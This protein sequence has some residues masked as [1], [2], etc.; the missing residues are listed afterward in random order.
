MIPVDRRWRVDVVHH[1]IERAAVVEIGVHG[2]VGEA[3]LRQAPCFR[4]VGESQVAV[5]A[6]GVLRQRDLRHVLEEERQI[7]RA[8]P[9][10]ERG[11]DCRVADVVDVIQV[12]GTAINAVG[13]EQILPAVIIQIHE[14]RRPAPVGRKDPRQISDLTELSHTSIQLEIVS[15]VLRMIPSLQP[16]VVEPEAFRV[17][18]CLEDIFPFWKHVERHDVGPSIVVE[19]GGVHSH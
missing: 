19:I 17:G 1:K 15:R 8:D 11:L 16:H 13:D 18:G 2:A 7:L 5:V 10:R 6:I 12:V 9:M 14:Q 3:R 4:H